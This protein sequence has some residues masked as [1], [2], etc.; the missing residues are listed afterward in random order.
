MT[1]VVPCSANWQLCAVKVGWDFLTPQV[2]G[3]QDWVGVFENVENAQ[4]D[5]AGTYKYGGWQWADA[6]SPY[7][8]N[9]TAND[10]YVIAYIVWNYGTKS[11]QAVAISAPY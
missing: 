6:G 8:T 10:G 7:S 5:P 11:Y 2:Y 4:N 1:Q 9:I 3:R